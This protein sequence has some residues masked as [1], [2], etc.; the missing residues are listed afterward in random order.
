MY[1]YDSDEFRRGDYVFRINGDSMEP[2]FHDGDIVLVMKRHTID[3]G[4]IGIFQVDNDIY[5]KKLTRD[6]LKS[7]NENYQTIKNS[8]DIICLGEVIGRIKDLK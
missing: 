5:I 7:L 2:E 8:R 4:A 3:Y 6:G 1:L